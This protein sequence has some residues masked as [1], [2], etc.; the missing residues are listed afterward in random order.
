[1]GQLENSSYFP[2]QESLKTTKHQQKE[3]LYGIRL[4]G[5]VASAHGWEHWIKWQRAIRSFQEHTHITCLSL[6]VF[7]V[8]CRG[9]CRKAA[10]PHLPAGLREQQRGSQHRQH[11]EHA[12]LQQQHGLAQRPLPRA[13]PDN[14]CVQTPERLDCGSFVKREWIA[15]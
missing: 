7:L 11:T 2:M 4:S 8:I 14:V 5:L 9:D 1:M 12:L 13:G 15:M 3:Q 6:P 10:S